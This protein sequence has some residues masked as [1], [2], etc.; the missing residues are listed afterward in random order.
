MSEDFML[1]K[2]IG[3]AKKDARLLKFLTLVPEIM[4]KDATD[5]KQ[6]TVAGCVFLFQI[7]GVSG[8]FAVYHDNG[9]P[10]LQVA[11]KDGEAIG[12]V[13]AFCE[14]G[15]P[16]PDEI[17]NGMLHGANKNKTAKEDEEEPEGGQE[18]KN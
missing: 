14:D 10:V 9:K 13:K 3:S 8:G 18:D 5:S 7:M 15:T 16:V 1:S 17:L 2:M 6:A 4:Y 12:E 11:F